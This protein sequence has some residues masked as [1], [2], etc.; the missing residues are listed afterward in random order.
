MT[1]GVPVVV[2]VLF[3]GPLKVRLEAAG[4]PVYVSRSRRYD[5]RTV[6]ELVRVLQRYGI[7]VVHTHGYKATILGAMA[8]RLTGARLVRTEHGRLEPE[9]RGWVRLKMRFNS[10]LET[11]VSRLAA[12]AVVFFKQIQQIANQCVSLFD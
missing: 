3:D 12:D 1:T 7:N 4:V 10:R 2:I 11:V 6:F 9:H 8:A 5:P